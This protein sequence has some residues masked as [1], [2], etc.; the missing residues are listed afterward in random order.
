MSTIYTA[1][2]D[3]VIIVAG[4]ASGMGEH[5][6]RQLTSFAKTIIIMDRNKAKGT[7]LTKELF[8]NVLFEKVEMTDEKDVKKVLKRLNDTHGEIDYFFNAAGSFMAGE[9]RD[10]P[11]KDWHEITNI[12]LQ[13]IING[14][15]AIYELML[16]NGHGHIINIASSAGLFPVP[17]MSLYGATKHAVVG[18]TLGLRMEAKKLKIKVSVVC[19][20]IVETPLYET[21]MYE[22][23]DKQRALHFLRTKANPQQPGKAARR[24]ITGTAKNKAII[25]TSVSTKLGYALFRI[26]PSLYMLVA[27][28]FFGLYRKHWRNK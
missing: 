2:K 22:N 5:I 13:P 19:P 14:T 28:R 4:G 23:V 7:K 27:Q 3:K 20:T 25:H 21:A 16:Q 12:N 1:Y 9:I 8:G 11:T 6:V 17:V 10:T 18:M 15:S 26:S 24:I